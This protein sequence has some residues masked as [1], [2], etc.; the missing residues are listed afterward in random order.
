MV[1]KSLPSPSG[2]TVRGTQCSL[3]F[4]AQRISERISERI[5]DAAKGIWGIYV[6]S[7][8][9]CF[10][11]FCH[12]TRCTASLWGSRGTSLLLAAAVSRSASAGQVHSTKK[13]HAAWTNSMKHK[14]FLPWSW[15]PAKYKAPLFSFHCTKPCKLR[16]VMLACWNSTHFDTFFR[17][18]FSTPWTPQ[19]PGLN[20]LRQW[21]GR[22]CRLP[23]LK[24]I[25]FRK[26]MS[27]RRML[28]G[29][30]GDCWD[31]TCTKL[32][33]WLEFSLPDPF[34]HG[35]KIPWGFLCSDVSFK[36]SKPFFT[37][38]ADFVASW[39]ICQIVCGGGSRWI[40]VDHSELK[41]LRDSNFARLGVADAAIIIAA[42]LNWRPNLK[43]AAVCWLL[44]R[45]KCLSSPI[46]CP[47]DLC[48]HLLLGLS[49]CFI[50]LYQ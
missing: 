21:F 42:G 30:G 20:W 50:Y 26:E 19:C 40:Q 17:C 6:L 47:D 16:Y 34:A 29:Q 12:E 2:L 4:E 10:V 22:I 44:W 25:A 39:N 48:V 41:R 23:T 1:P 18:S 31:T 9:H 5:T 33:C 43:K 45:V 46:L 38:S 28:G 14:E 49:L 3:E 32:W 8:W 15:R 36:I 27:W 24:P 37:T 7:F 35:C 13:M 11:M